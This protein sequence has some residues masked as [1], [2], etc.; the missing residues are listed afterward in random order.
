MAVGAEPTVTELMTEVVWGRVLEFP[1]REKRDREPAREIAPSRDSHLNIAYREYRLRM[2]ISFAILSIIICRF[3]IIQPA[4]RDLSR[5]SS[6]WIIA[7]LMHRNLQ[8]HC[9]SFVL[10]FPCSDNRFFI[11]CE[12]ILDYNESKWKLVS[13]LASLPSRIYHGSE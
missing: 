6:S 9:N 3:K 1:R 8:S 11:S 7:K 13:P 2:D 5:R 10:Q 4:R 12:M